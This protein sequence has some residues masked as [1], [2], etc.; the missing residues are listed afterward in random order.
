[1]YGGDVYDLQSDQLKPLSNLHDWRGCL[2]WNIVRGNFDP[3]WFP[4]INA[5]RNNHA[6]LWSAYQ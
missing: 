3:S 4:A 5:V 2:Q 6:F 1:M